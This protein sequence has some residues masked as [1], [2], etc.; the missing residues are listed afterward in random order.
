[1]FL[2]DLAESGKQVSRDVRVEDAAG[3]LLQRVGVPFPSLGPQPRGEAR[4]LA[5]KRGVLGLLGERAEQRRFR[6]FEV[7]QR[8]LGDLCQR[9]E[10]A[11]PL[12]R[13]GL[14]PKSQLEDGGQLRVASGSAKDGLEHVRRVDSELIV[15]V[16]D[17]A[18]GRRRFRVEARLEH[19]AIGLERGL[20]I[21]HLDRVQRGDSLF[22]PA[23]RV[24]VGR[25]ARL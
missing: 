14:R 12:R 24:G 16:A 2:A 11:S 20:R 5:M 25:S 4:D 23:L 8:V 18:H 1:M 22:E 17:P 19:L 9:A 6:P 13:L 15:S 10:G 7:L 3:P 21:L